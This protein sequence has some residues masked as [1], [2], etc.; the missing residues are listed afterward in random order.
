MSIRENQKVKEISGTK[1]A[2]GTAAWP[3]PG[4]SWGAGGRTTGGAG[5]RAREVLLF[6]EKSWERVT[7]S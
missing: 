3:G 2:A 1:H 5:A 6:E 7:L 4:R